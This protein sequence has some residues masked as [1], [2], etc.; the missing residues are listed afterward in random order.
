MKKIE[1]FFLSETIGNK[2]I[3]SKLKEQKFIIKANKV[4]QVKKA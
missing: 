2:V 1:K 4:T 3:K